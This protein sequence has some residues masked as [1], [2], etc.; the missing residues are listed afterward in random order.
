MNFWD[1][2]NCD[3]R[4]TRVFSLQ[5]AIVDCAARGEIGEN[6]VIRSSK[7]WI[8]SSENIETSRLSRI[9]RPVCFIR[10][11]CEGLGSA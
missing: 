6:S 3:G 10:L 9:V 7:F 2:E 5:A 8:R 11:F 1:T 4:A